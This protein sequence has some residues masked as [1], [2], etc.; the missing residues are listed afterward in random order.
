MCRWNSSTL[1]Q[2]LVSQMQQ[3]ASTARLQKA[4]Q[5]ATLFAAR[6]HQGPLLRHAW[7]AV[8]FSTGEIPDLVM[9]PADARSMLVA[10]L[11]SL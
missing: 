11:L 3:M 6:Q 2:L 9:D 10:A 4:Q 5:L 7:C 8:E 1:E